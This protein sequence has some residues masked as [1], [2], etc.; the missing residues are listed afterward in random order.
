MPHRAIPGGPAL[1]L[2]AFCFTVVA[3][4]LAALSN[5]L[6]RLG[7]MRGGGFGISDQ[8]LVRDLLRL[9][10]EPAFPGGLVLYGIALAAWMRVLSTESVYVGYVL[11]ISVAFMA[12]SIGDM[13]V[14]RE[15][16]SAQRVVG[17][18]VILLGI[19]LVAR[20]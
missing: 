4:L 5:I 10:C 6:L 7:L 12:T 15:P 11:L 9:M 3:A 19:V 8:G 14:F 2:T 13:L 16:F 17:G 18:V 20:S 1:S